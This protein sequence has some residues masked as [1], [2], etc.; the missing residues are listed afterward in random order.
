MPLQMMI[1]LLMRKSNHLYCWC[2]FSIDAI[3][4]VKSLKEHLRLPEKTDIWLLHNI[5]CF[6]HVSWAMLNKLKNDI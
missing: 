1:K 6:I 4:H 5:R 3:G 2:Q